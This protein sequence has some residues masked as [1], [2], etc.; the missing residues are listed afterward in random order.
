MTCRHPVW[1]VILNTAERR[2]IEAVIELCREARERLQ[3]NAPFRLR[4]LLD[5]TL[6]ELGKELARLNGDRAV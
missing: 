3:P 4:V 1:E 5:M 2:K 6:L